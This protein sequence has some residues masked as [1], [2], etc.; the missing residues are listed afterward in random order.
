MYSIVHITCF[1]AVYLCRLSV[2]NP[3]MGRGHGVF[4]YFLLEGL[5]GAAETDG[6]VYQ[7]VYHKAS[8]FT[9]NKQRPF[10]SGI[11]ERPIILGVMK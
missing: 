11:E 10:K 2:E 7:Y 4:T 9:H 5:K 6:E 3:H 1:I 8:K